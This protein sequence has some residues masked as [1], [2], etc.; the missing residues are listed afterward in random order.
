MN[1]YYEDDFE[2]KNQL[3]KKIKGE[4]LAINSQDTT[5]VR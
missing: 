3:K 5:L 4:L 1:Y 2:N